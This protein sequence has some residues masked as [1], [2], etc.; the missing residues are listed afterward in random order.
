MSTSSFAKQG[1]LSAILNSSTV[2]GNGVTW[3]Q[4]SVKFKK[5]SK[6]K[7]FKPIKIF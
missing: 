2:A 5:F 7:I 3:D 4:S 1:T 6:V